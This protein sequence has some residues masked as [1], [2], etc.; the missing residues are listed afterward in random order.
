[1]ADFLNQGLSETDKRAAIVIEKYLEACN[2]TG[3]AEKTKLLAWTSLYHS[4]EQLQSKCMDGVSVDWFRVVCYVLDQRR[5]REASK[6]QKRIEEVSRKRQR[7]DRDDVENDQS[8]RT[9]RSASKKLR[10][11][12]SVMH[13]LLENFPRILSIEGSDM[14]DALKDKNDVSISHRIQRPML[15]EQHNIPFRIDGSEFQNLTISERSELG[16]RLSLIETLGS[17]FVLH[18]S[19]EITE[20]LRQKIPNNLQPSNISNAQLCEICQ[21]LVKWIQWI[22]VYSTEHNGLSHT[23]DYLQEILTTAANCASIQISS[24][25][26]ILL[27]NQDSVL[28]KRLS[29]QLQ[30]DHLTFIEFNIN[31]NYSNRHGIWQNPKFVDWLKSNEATNIIAKNLETLDSLPMYNPSGYETLQ[32]NVNASGIFILGIISVI[33]DLFNEYWNRLNGVITAIRMCGSTDFLQEL[34]I[35]AN[36]PILKSGSSSSRL[37]VSLYP[38]FFK[39]VLQRRLFLSI[40]YNINRRSLFFQLGQLFAEIEQLLNRRFLPKDIHIT[41]LP[42]SEKISLARKEWEEIQ[43]KNEERRKAIEEGERV[44]LQS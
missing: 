1:M 33:F 27:A 6:F 44:S 25:T 7:E 24:N 14:D 22:G 18:W 31:Q 4:Q 43:K 9:S 12:E 16:N 5:L 41:S 15:E 19:Y 28:N 10:T 30:S 38:I 8:P 3:L 37:D 34:K 40:F 32:H 23:T 26:A 20:E 36:L 21:C 11:D 2:K 42:A 13:E 17:K 35:L 29:L 39:F